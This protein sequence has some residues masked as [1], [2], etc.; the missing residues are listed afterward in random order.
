MSKQ[1]NQ[2]PDQGNTSS[3]TPESFK[4]KLD[5]KT[6]LSMIGGIGMAVT[7]T[8][9]GYC[10]IINNQNNQ[11]KKLDYVIKM[12]D[13]K[14]GI[15]QFNNYQLKL[16]IDNPSLRFPP[17]LENKQE[18]QSKE[19]FSSNINAVAFITNEYMKGSE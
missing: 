7:F 9:M 19:T 1:Y 18:Q 2:I 5:L 11:S 17:A 16:Q 12:M 13:T 14:L 10:G 15:D 4:M 8:V 6:M 3:F